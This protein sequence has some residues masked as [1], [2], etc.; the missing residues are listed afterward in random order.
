MAGIYI[1][2]PFCRRACHYCDFHFSTNLSRKTAL[3]AMLER[4]IT[5]QANYLRGAPITT[6]YFGGGTPSLLSA[7]ELNAI[8][9]Q[10]QRHFSWAATAEITLEAN[11]DDLT[12]AYLAD[13][14]HTPINRLS[15]GIQSFSDTDLRAFNR[16]HTAAEA[17]R[18]IDHALHFGFDNLSIDLIYGAPTTDA[19]QWQKN[20][21]ILAPLPIAHLSCYAL[22]V[23]PKTAL[24]AMIRAGKTPAVMD[25]TAVL[26][27]QILQ[28]WLPK[29]GFEQYEISN[30]ARQAQYAQHNTAYWQGVPYLGIGPSAH[31][32]DTASRQWNVA[33]NAL[34]IS[35][36]QN[37]TLPFE[38]EILTERD[39]INE[40]IMT[41]LRTKWGCRLAHIDS[42]QAGRTTA[43]TAVIAEA[44]AY[45]TKNWLS[46]QNDTLHLTPQGKLHAD[47][48]AAQ[49][50]VA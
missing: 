28:D 30:F 16:A 35:S 1:H 15:I 39:R 13:L 48:I 19:A 31:S 24:A 10:L 27:W 11:P 38:K 41:T 2:I 7:S 22:T 20:L 36:L 50:F 4:E 34:Y 33:N 49:L 23:E 25:S 47:S 12:D 5:L 29:A 40:Y 37:N 46:Y 17:T 9:A 3:L 44:E 21:A 14:R 43:R 8:F 42:L 6:I 18:A 45:I 32:F 26:H